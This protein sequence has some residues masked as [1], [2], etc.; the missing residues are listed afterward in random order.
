MDRA[1][2]S[3]TVTRRP[4][5]SD[6]RFAAEC[7]AA[8]RLTRVTTDDLRRLC[9]RPIA[10][11]V[12][13]SRR[14][15][16]RDLRNQKRDTFRSD[17]V[18]ANQP[19]PRLLWR[20]VRLLLGRGRVPASDAIS[21]HEFH[22]F[23]TD[24]VQAVRATTAGGLSASPTVFRSPTSKRWRHYWRLPNKSCIADRLPT[25]QLKLVAS[26]SYRIR[27]AV[28][29]YRPSVTPVF[30]IPHVSLYWDGRTESAGGHSV[31]RRRR[32]PVCLCLAPVR[33]PL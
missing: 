8:K 4:R 12:W 2:L 3:A 28:F 29:L 6:P 31:C 24:K 14:E 10:N 33:S 21:V 30:C 11:Q 32:R 16:R 26:Q 25:P 20:S 9:Y 18:A 1:V 15:S 5:P 13:H 17:T 7:G 23:F 19:S 27:T 22:R